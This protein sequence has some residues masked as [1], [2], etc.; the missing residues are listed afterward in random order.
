MDVRLTGLSK[1]FA[2]FAAINDMSLEIGSGELLG[3]LGPSGSGKTTLLRLI[4]GLEF[5]DQGQIFFGDIDASQHSIGARNVGFVFQHYALFRHM[6]VAQNIGFGLRILPRATRPTPQ[7][8]RR[9]VLSLLDLV[10]LSGLEDRYPHQLSGGQRQRVALARAMAIDPQILLLDEPFGALDSQVRRQLRHWL[11]QMHDKTGYTTVFVTHDQEEALELSDR[12]VVMN[13]G[14]IEQIGSADE[15]YDH[16]VTP[17][18]YEFIGES[19]NLNVDLRDGKIFYQDRPIGLIN[20]LDGGAARLYFRPN[21][22]QI[23]AEGDAGLHGKIFSRHRVGSTRR[24]EI[25][26]DGGDHVE[27]ELPRDCA[28]NV[29]DCLTFRPRFWKVFTD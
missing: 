23:I 17:F 25:V 15:V 4:A 11:R 14:R 18:V 22:A 29:G 21:E 5:P 13:H 26:F 27:I 12:V 7:E 8:I 1:E 20:H 10:Q 24:A 6:T 3:L 16:P 19:S 9:H 2:G 28:L